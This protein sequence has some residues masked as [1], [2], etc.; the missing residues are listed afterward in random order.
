MSS[1]HLA[2]TYRTNL[3]GALRAAHV[4]QHVRLGGWV[5]R[6]RDL[7]G[8]AFVDLRDRA[9]IVQVSFDPRTCPPDVCAGAAALGPETVVLV[10]GEVVARP[11]AMRNAELATGEI[12]VRANALRVVGPATP[13]AIPVARAQ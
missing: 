11:E 5:H 4:G 12:E 13:P 9:G 8:L 3:C 1:E 6:S 7:G 2:T 10:E